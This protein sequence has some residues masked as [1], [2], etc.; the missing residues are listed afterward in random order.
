MIALLINNTVDG[1]SR[2]LQ[3]F[4]RQMQAPIPP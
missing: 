3:K 4:L 2:Q 1:H